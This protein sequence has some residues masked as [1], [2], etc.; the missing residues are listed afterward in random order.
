MS[1]EH[2]KK[3]KDRNQTAFDVVARATSTDEDD[4]DDETESESQD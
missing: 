3:R 2:P 1:I 4:Q